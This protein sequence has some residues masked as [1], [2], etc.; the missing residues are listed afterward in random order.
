MG[1][2]SPRGR[3]GGA[4]LSRWALSGAVDDALEVVVAHRQHGVPRIARTAHLSVRFGTTMFQF[5]IGRWATSRSRAAP[6]LLPTPRRLTFPRARI[7][8]RACAPP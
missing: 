7:G 8:Y 2:R 4:P 3:A 6:P 5:K 1:T